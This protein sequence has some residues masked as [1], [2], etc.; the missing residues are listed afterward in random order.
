MQL[1]SLTVSGLRCFRNPVSLTDF[2]P[3]INIIFGPN[4]L[5][6]STLIG[7]LIL[8]FCNRHDVT[9]EAIAGYRPWGTDLSPLIELEFIVGGRCYH[10]EKGFLDQAK[11]L[12]S[13][14][15]GRQYVRLACGRNADD[16]VRK[17]ILA[18]LPGRGL[19]KG[20]DWGLAQLLWMPQDKE[21]F[22]SPCV[23]HQLVDHL[24][25]LAGATIFTQ[26]DDRIMQ[27][28][29]NRFADIY[30]PK[31]A[32]YKAGSKVRQAEARLQ[33]LEL[34]LEKARQQ[35][36]EIA[37]QAAQ[38]Q[39]TEKEAR[40]R[41]ETFKRLTEKQRLLEDQMEHIK[42]LKGQIETAAAMAAA[43][44]QR[45]KSLRQDWD[46]MVTWTKQ[47]RE[48]AQK[49]EMVTANL[50]LI[51]EQ[52]QKQ[53]QQV[54]A[55]KEQID[56]LSGQLK[57]ANR[58]LNRI[59]KLKQCI[60]L[61]TQIEALTGKLK[62]MDTIQKD[63]AGLLAQLSTKSVPT[64]DGLAQAQDLQR[65]I[66]IGQGQA[67]AQGLRVDFQP[68]R[69]LDVAVITAGEK[70]HHVVGPGHPLCMDVTA[71]QVELEIATVGRFI[72]SSGAKELKEILAQLKAD[73]ETLAATLKTY[74]SNDVD[75]LAR[76]FQSAEKKRQQLDYLQA[77]QTDL[78]SEYNSRDELE[79][80]RAQQEQELH[81]QCQ[82]LGL[83]KGDLESLV[84]PD[85]A[86]LEKGTRKLEREEQTAKTEY[87]NLERNWQQAKTEQQQLTHELAR[88][89]QM[90][91]TAVDTIE[92]LLTAYKG[93]R[94]RL[95]Q[96]VNKALIEKEHQEKHLKEL[97]SQLPTDADS[98]ERNAQRMERIIGQQEEQ[99]SELQAKITD[100]K[101]Q[102]NVKSEAG[103][104]SEINQLE[105]E[106]ELVK[107]E[108]ERLKLN[109]RA[110]KLLHRLAHARHGAMLADLTE[111]IRQGLN[112]L[113]QMVT[114]K[115]DR[116]L[117]LE[118]D[119]SL[120]G[121]RVDDEDYLQPLDVFSI[122]T[123]E[124]MLLLA[125]LALAQFLSSEERQ[126][127]VLDDA[128]VNSDGLRRQRILQL[129]A[130]ARDRF[131]LLILTCH[132]EMYEQLPGK[133][134]DLASLL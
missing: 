30:T 41:R 61:H 86:E 21:R 118:A 9:G 44:E 58:D 89:Q 65:R 125:R 59:Y 79:R 39:R 91:Q 128:L 96:S 103:L 7:G 113:F 49:I 54:K 121:L 35:A 15:E 42:A 28:I 101:A 29:D 116:N 87:S 32:V 12:L 3:G 19:A 66:E 75:Q 108:Y 106:Y 11:S 10:L 73:K 33:R 98:I 78:L 20:S 81:Q 60:S 55:K 43:A 130:A 37:H 133:R 25:R 114:T 120:A 57:A 13:E 126:L 4:E 31:T 62:A 132:P 48:A 110:V 107:K 80:A 119:L 131:Q 50:T 102:I 22:T 63:I 104:Y 24:R 129:L 97:R 23:S 85:V 90:V 77:Q 122:G 69:N 68:E 112:D 82:E 99:L 67:K 92:A 124:Q 40:S 38:L 134:Y 123:Q 14:L 71:A 117:Q 27:L 70:T 36:M 94:D 74:A 17:F 34:E 51:E 5:G 105:E 2:D 52:V 47:G 26:H 93:N 45:W 46:Q 100:L 111:P 76:R 16:R 109:A 8:A 56:Q 64:D 83:E 18:Q 95:E 53:G 72:I 127:V 6:K 115:T 1:C 84:L 88:H